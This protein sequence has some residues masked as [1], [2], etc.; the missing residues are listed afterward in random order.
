MLLSVVGSGQWPATRSELYKIATELLLEE[1]DRDHSLK[2]SGA[3][4]AKELQP[5]AGAVF[6]ARLISDVEGIGLTEQSG[7]V[8]VP[9][10]RSLSFV[11]LDHVRAALTR[12]LAASGRFVQSHHQEEAHSE[13][14]SGASALPIAF[15]PNPEASLPRQPPP[16]TTAKPEFRYR[17]TRRHCSAPASPLANGV[18]SDRKAACA[19]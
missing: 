10:Y 14:G 6:A 16:E 12:R 4:S 17:L 7:T 11:N 3:L 1:A 15:A 13:I 2:K 19:S 8:G 9:G 5:V 18:C